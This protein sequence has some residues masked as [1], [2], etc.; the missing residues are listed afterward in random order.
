[1]E[2]CRSFKGSAPLGGFALMGGWLALA[3]ARLP[4]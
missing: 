2:R 3:V 4:K 1:M